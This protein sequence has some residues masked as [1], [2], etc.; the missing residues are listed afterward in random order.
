MKG[1]RSKGDKYD[2]IMSDE[3]MYNV[4]DEEIATEL[5]SRLVKLL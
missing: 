3:V 5:C 4:M 2:P 1:D